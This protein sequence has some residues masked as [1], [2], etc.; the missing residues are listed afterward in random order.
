MKITKPIIEFSKYF[1]LTIL[2]IIIA[3][4]LFI[5]MT[6]IPVWNDCHDSHVQECTQ[7]HILNKTYSVC[8]GFAYEPRAEDFEIPC[9]FH[10]NESCKGIPH[11]CVLIEN[12]YLV[13]VRIPFTKLEWRFLE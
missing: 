13:G 12:E 4:G 5:I 7:A 10:P 6:N 11:G 8:S 9:A 2:G 3:L 1:I